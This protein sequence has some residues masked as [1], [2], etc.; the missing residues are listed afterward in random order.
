M[1]EM[2]LLL[3]DVFRMADSNYEGE[4][5]KEQFMKTILRLRSNLD[6]QLINEMFYAVDTNLNGNFFIIKDYFLQIN[7]SSFYMHM[8][9]PRAKRLLLIR[10]R[11]RKSLL[12]C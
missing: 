11:Q 12:L 8:E 1:K 3:V 2:G 4:I 7:M 5:T 6:E 10:E 9:D